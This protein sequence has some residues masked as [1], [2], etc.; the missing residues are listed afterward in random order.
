MGNSI[1]TKVFGEEEG[2]MRAALAGLGGEGEPWGSS[3]FLRKVLLPLPNISTPP[4]PH[5]NRSR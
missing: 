1:N 3:P 5:I 4:P 2:G